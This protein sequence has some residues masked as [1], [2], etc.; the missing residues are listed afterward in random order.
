[1]NIR[2]LF[3]KISFVALLMITPIM[4]ESCITT[5]LVVYAASQKKQNQ[6]QTASTPNNSS[7]KTTNGNSMGSNSNNESNI[8]RLECLGEG[9][10]RNEAI[11]DALRSGLEQVYG[12]FISSDTRILN[13]KVIK[14]EIVSLSSGNVTD[15]KVLTESNVGNTWIVTLEGGFSQ[16]K[17]AKYVESKGGAITINT[18]VYAQNEKIRLAREEA[19]KKIEKQKHLQAELMAPSCI[20]YVVRVSEPL[21]LSSV[22]IAN[23]SELSSSK[24][25]FYK[26]QQ[27]NNM[28]L[29]RVTVGAK[30]NKNINELKKLVSKDDVV[31]FGMSYDA[32]WRHNWRLYRNN[33]EISGHDPDPQYKNCLISTFRSHNY[34]EFDTRV[35]EP[36]FR[37]TELVGYSSFITAREGSVAWIMCY[38]YFL[39]LEEL[40]SFI[41]EFRVEYKN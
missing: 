18:S 6:K 29:A 34:A 1:M 10:T 8:I 36:N 26:R 33:I 11:N 24:R 21:L 5:A 22:R 39:T 15:Y 27:N 38:D 7:K 3:R 41:A 12:T 20:D 9:N 13:D 35:S 28:Y 4:F 25:E 40:N 23:Y 14:D 16:Q 2:I 30:F 17:L 32:S 19:A 37:I 31:Y